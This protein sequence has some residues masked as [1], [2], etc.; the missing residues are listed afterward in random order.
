MTISHH[1]ERFHELPIHEFD[2][3]DTRPRPAAG[4][5]A[6]RLSLE[7]GSKEDFG[8]L[9]QSFLRSV[10]PAGV[11][12]VVI[13]AW[14]Q[15]GYS[16][17]DAAVEAITA[18]ADRLPAL[19]ALFL[20]EVTFDECEISWLEMGDVTPLL[21]AFPGLRSL[22][23][24]GGMDLVLEPVRHDRLTSL[25]FESGG[26]P[27]AV[28]RAVAGSELP[29]L[30]S[31]ELWLGVDEYGG[32]TTMDDLAPFLDGTRLPALRH[33]GL[34]NSELQDDIA[35]AVAHAPVVAR[36][37]SLSLSMGVLSDEGVAA[38]LEG[39]PLTHLRALDLHHHYVGE[40][41]QQRL[42]QALPGVEIDLSEAE[43]ADQDDDDDR[44]VSVAE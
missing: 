16:S 28:V 22:T 14:W 19:E 17:V 38:L 21:T 27:S 43:G 36:L 44:Y 29:A 20:G 23:V 4:S 31:L 18:E 33:L 12:A 40:E 13:G 42:R 30:E 8:R 41:L 6:W 5:V 26:L 15:E 39:Q 2:A 24:R 3:E 32:D 10:D 1:I 11:R 25:S 37:E 7:Y 34:Q 9:W 35:A